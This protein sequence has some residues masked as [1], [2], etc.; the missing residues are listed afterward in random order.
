LID[1]RDWAVGAVNRRVHRNTQ[2]TLN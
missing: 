1:A 2:H